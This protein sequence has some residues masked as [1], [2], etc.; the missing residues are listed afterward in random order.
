MDDAARPAGLGVYPGT[1]ICP[2]RGPGH[3]MLRLKF[4][5]GIHGYST[6]HEN[7]DG[8]DEALRR[9][10]IAHG[11]E[12]AVFLALFKVVRL[13]RVLSGASGPSPTSGEEQA[14]AEG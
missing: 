10:L 1:S 3:K 9:A 7:R 2:I 14:H 13:L 12:G 4:R 6:P 11:V 8:R 5:G